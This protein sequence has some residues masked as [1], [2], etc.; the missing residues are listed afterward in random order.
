MEVQAAWTRELRIEASHQ[1]FEGHFPG[2]PILPGVSLLAEVLES[3][4]DEPALAVGLG[5][6]PH[7]I[8]AKFFIPVEPGSSLAIAWRATAG[9]L[10][11]RVALGGRDVASGQF[12]RADV[13]AAA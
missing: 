6:A 4:Y 3:G 9:A 10:H 7:L 1:A 11:W 2:R 12:A 13:P 5:P 8:A